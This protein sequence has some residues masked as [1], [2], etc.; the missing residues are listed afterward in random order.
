MID[1]SNSR[2]EYVTLTVE[3]RCD[4]LFFGLLSVPFSLSL[5]ACAT[6]TGHS[7]FEA[8]A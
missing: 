5:C 3:Y 7:T 6:T 4:H 8:S 2:D 1:V